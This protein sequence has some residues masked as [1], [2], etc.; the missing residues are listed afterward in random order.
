[1]IPEQRR[2]PRYDARGYRLCMGTNR[3]GGPCGAPALRGMDLCAKHGAKHPA[4]KR[5]AR[6]R[7]AE[8]V[9]PA[10]A[11][12]AR[13]MVQAERSS[14]RQSAAN[15]LL[16]R[17]GWGRTAV[18][19]AGDARAVLVQRIL[20][21][22]R[23]QAEEHADPAEDPRVQRVI[24]QATDPKVTYDLTHNPEPLREDEPYAQ[25]ARDAQSA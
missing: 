13:E 23:Q 22:Q 15:S 9:D 25:H 12:L 11:V 6:L 18:I 5:A 10:I 21:V 14:D 7:L 24:E 16:D 2:E 20:E 3:E 4:A 1:M 8:L 17:A 19:Q